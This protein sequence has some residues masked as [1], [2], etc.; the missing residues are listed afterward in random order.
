MIRLNLKSTLAPGVLA[1][2]LCGMGTARAQYTVTGAT[3]GGGKIIVGNGNLGPL[4]PATAPVA[5]SAGGFD[6][7][8]LNIGSFAT[9]IAGDTIAFV[10]SNDSLLNNGTVIGGASAGGNGYTAIIF[11][12]A[13]LSN[14]MVTNNGTLTGGNGNTSGPG[15]GIGIFIEATGGALSGVTVSNFGS[16]TGGVGTGVGSSGGYGIAI[17]SNGGTL[18]GVTLTNF[19]SITGGNSVNGGGGGGGITLVSFSSAV[20]GVKLINFG[21]VTGGNDTGGAAGGNG[22]II[23]TNT[24]A[25]SSVTLTNFGS[26]NGGNGTGGGGGIGI[27]YL[28]PGGPVSGVTLTNFGRIAGGNDSAGGTAGPGISSYLGHLTINNWGAI[29][30]GSGLAPV[31]INLQTSSNNTINL[32]GHSS[33]NGKI[34]AHGAVDSNA[35][36]LNFT[37][38]SPVAIAA[39]KAQ[40]AAQGVLTGHDSSGTFT[41]RGVNYNYDPLVLS[42]NVTSY[43]LQGL[44]PNQQAIG[45]SLDSITYNPAPGSPLFTL[46]NAIDQSGNVPA[47]LEELSPQKFEIYGDLAIVNAD[48]TVHSVDARLNN[49]RDGSESIDTSGIGG[50]TV[51]GLTKDDGKTSKEIQPAAPAP[52]RWGFFATGNGL[53][54]RGNSHDADLQEGKADSAGTIAGIDGKVGDHGVIGALFAYDNAAVTMGGDNSHATIESYTGGLYGAWHDDGFYL[55][56]L[57]A[58]TRNDYKSE[59]NILFP[60]AAATANGSTNGN[61]ATANLDGGYDWN[62]TDRLTLGPV[63]G[64]Q[65]VHLDVDGFNEIGASGADL[66]VNSQSMDSLQSRVG[67]RADYHLLTLATSSFAA[68]IH[69]AW[70]HEYLND[71]RGIG[72]NFIGDG[73]APFS[74]QTAPPLR[75]AAVVGLGLNFTFHNRLTLFAEYELELWRASYFEQTV[76]GGARISF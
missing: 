38:M 60:G 30:A 11:D 20:S 25:V 36:N 64:V 19:G 58:Y 3:A 63:L 13:S 42:L 26:V 46:F 53:F 50:A 6:N 23:G 44:T 56:A 45:A 52:N 10:T 34:S 73:L 17:E 68:E 22:I 43:Q 59:R 24:G 5:L 18:S 28:S 27:G 4:G 48:F 21:S 72:A 41:V 33:V 9:V 62:L 51:A 7:V 1:L 55:N 47:S 65:Y 35:L 15:A 2:I 54:F 31:A 40:L 8:T 14:E 69:A 39:L 76:N 32:D 49:L 67:V 16:V 61:Q 29:F 57:G 37:G 71:S 12:A 70:Q 75:D 66:A 74:V